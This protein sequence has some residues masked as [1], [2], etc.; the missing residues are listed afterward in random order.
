[1]F[2]SPRKSALSQ[3]GWQFRAEGAAAVAEL[4]SQLIAKVDA[5]LGTPLALLIENLSDF[6]ASEA[7]FPLTQL[8]KVVLREDGFVVGEAETSTWGQAWGLAQ[9][10]KAGRRGL[11]LV[12]GEM[13]GDN[14][15]GTPLGRLRRAD[16]PAGRG[17][18]IQAVGRAR[19]TWQ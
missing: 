12:P 13:D 7:E 2:L 6:A 8:I 16:F 4:C 17:F 5:G 15:M 3:R 10:L 9:P 19:S 18:L 14:L 1:M 11:L